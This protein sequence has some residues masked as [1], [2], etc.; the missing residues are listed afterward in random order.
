MGATVQSFAFEGSLLQLGEFVSP[1][2]GKAWRGLKCAELSTTVERR[3]KGEG[4]RESV[5][6]KKRP[7]AGWKCCRVML[8]LCAV[9]S[10]REVS[11][12]AR[13]FTKMWGRV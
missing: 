4:R 7:A 11:S 6:C 13:L 5:L 2:P 10:V 9:G 3:E 12:T 1:R 8:L